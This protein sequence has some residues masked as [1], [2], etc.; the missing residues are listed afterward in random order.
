MILREV[1]L[2]TNTNTDKHVRRVT[3][4]TDMQGGNGWK[5]PA[6][7]YENRYEMM[8]S[9]RKSETHPSCKLIFESTSTSSSSDTFFPATFRNCHCA[10][11]RMDFTMCAFAPINIR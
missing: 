7:T 8:L 6:V 2:T 4:E 1:P 9:A 5:S 10:D 3:D 11:S